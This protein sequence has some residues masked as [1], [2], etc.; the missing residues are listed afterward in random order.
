MT[1]TQQTPDRTLL[2]L[3]QAQK[4]LDLTSEELT[5]FVR[6]GQL[7]VVR[8]IAGQATYQKDGTHKP[9]EVSI[10][11]ARNPRQGVLLTDIEDLRQTSAYQ[12]LLAN[13]AQARHEAAEWHETFQEGIDNLTW[14]LTAFVEAKR[15][16]QAQHRS[17]SADDPDSIRRWFALAA[18]ECIR[19]NAA[20]KQDE[21]AQEEALD[22]KEAPGA[23]QA[24]SDT[25]TAQ[26]KRARGRPKKHQ[27][28]V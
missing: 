16:L 10:P 18:E 15:A 5:S 22:A 27:D 6:S 20:K 7:S 19:S 28:V 2:T 11:E 17:V 25:R 4:L 12:S 14:L 26:T 21:T 3:P 1:H 9:I 8:L 23:S 13:K 24:P